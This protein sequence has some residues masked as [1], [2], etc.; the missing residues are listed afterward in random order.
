LTLPEIVAKQDEAI[1][2]VH[3]ILPGYSLASSRILLQKHHW[4]AHSLLGELTERPEAVCKRAGVAPPSS[5]DAPLSP[6][7]HGTCLICYEDGEMFSLQ[8][9]HAFCLGKSSV[10]REL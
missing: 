6:T 1:Q 4:D 9:G 10:T 3:T 7:K 8:C 5:E 2:M